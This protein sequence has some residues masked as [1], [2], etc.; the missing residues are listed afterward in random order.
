MGIL[1][2]VINNMSGATQPLPGQPTQTPAQVAPVVGP[3]A[4]SAALGG[5]PQVLPNGP[6]AAVGAASPVN[7]AQV[8]AVQAPAAAAPVAGG[9]APP[10]QPG[11]GVMGA[12][13]D[14]FTQNPNSFWGSV[15]SNSIWGA[16]NA[17]RA[18]GYKLAEANLAYRQQV[19]N[20]QQAEALVGKTKAETGELGGK[21]AMERADAAVKNVDAVR[22]QKVISS[23]GPTD[24][25]DEKDNISTVNPDGS[26]TVKHYT[27]TMLSVASDLLNQANDHLETANETLM[28]AQKGKDPLAIM[29]AKA[30]VKAAEN[31]RDI[32]MDSQRG[33]A[34]SMQ[35]QENQKTDI[36]EKG[37][38]EMKKAQLRAA[39]TAAAMAGRGGKLPTSFEPG[40][41]IP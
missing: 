24:F 40:P 6:A 8:G 3:F 29:R 41:D 25:V 1:Q 37:E 14:F 19:A 18:Y 13:H 20:T 36:D 23:L 28:T 31:Q 38:W 33:V 30:A 2:D 39:A 34:T 10:L 27:P 7:G 26:I 4:T 22:K 16:S 32:A 15:L 5:T 9:P 12:A 17:H 21:E 11:R 35:G